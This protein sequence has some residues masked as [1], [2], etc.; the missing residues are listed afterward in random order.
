[1]KKSSK[2]VCGLVALGASSGL[3]NASVY[4]TN[5]TGYTLGD[6]NGQNGWTSNGATAT[7]GY[8][9]SIAGVWGGRAASIG[10]VD[11][12]SP[13]IPYVSHSVSTPMVDTV[14]NMNASFSALF[15]V[16]DSDSGYGTTPAEIAAAADRD[17]F[18]FRLQNSTGDNLFSFILTPFAQS[19]TPETTTRFDTYSWSTGVGAPTVALAGLAAQ[20]NNA[21]TFTVNFF[22][23]GA[24]NVGFNANINNINYFSG[25]LAGLSGQTISNLGAFWDTTTGAAGPGSNFMIF[26]NVSLI[27]EPSSAL[28]GLLGASFAFVR[29]RRA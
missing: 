9:Q 11:P 18:G 13:A 6:L 27:P 20:E 22:D 1:M 10:Y 14:G 12:V 5:F 28:L 15:Q 17:S 26:D 7:T 24:G 4:S 23:A 3:A 25:T 2:F 29:R 19:A 16:Q 21:Y 8:V